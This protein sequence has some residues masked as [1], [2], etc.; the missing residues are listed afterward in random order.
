SDRHA[1]D[2]RARPARAPA[3]GRLVGSR[4]RTLEVE[5][6]EGADLGLERGD[7]GKAA[8][9]EVARRVGAAGK[10]RRRREIRLGRK[11]QFLVRRQHGDALRSSFHPALRLFLA[12]VVIRVHRFQEWSGS[13]NS[14]SISAL[15]LVFLLSLGIRRFLGEAPVCF[16]TVSPAGADGRSLIMKLTTANFNLPASKQ[17]AIVFDDTLIGFG[18]R[19]RRGIGGKVIRN[20]IVQYRSHGRSRRMRVGSAETLTAAQARAEA[21]KLLARVE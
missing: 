14:G 7:I 1:I 9:E 17:D 15:Y 13:I 20:W 4:T 5:I 16:P 3:R 10:A 12:F 21:K 2:L 18:L 6:D 11:L 8:F 19:L